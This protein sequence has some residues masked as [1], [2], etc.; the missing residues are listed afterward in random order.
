MTQ[1]VPGR[2]GCPLIFALELCA[3][4]KGRVLAPF[5]SENRCFGLNSGMVFEGMRLR[6]NRKRQYANSKW[7]LRNLFVGARIL[8][9]IS[10]FLPTLGLKTGLEFRG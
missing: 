4:P 2:E 6:M 3:T 7:I 1:A 5:W 10:L 8:V 9:M